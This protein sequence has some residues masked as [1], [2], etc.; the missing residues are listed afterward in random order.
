MS[1]RT[2]FFLLVVG[3]TVIPFLIAS[4]LMIS[5]TSGGDE[6][7]LFYEYYIT[8]RWVRKNLSGAEQG[9]NLKKLIAEKPKSVEF[10]V[11]NGK[12]HILYSTV[13][14]PARDSN[15]DSSR[16]LK[17]VHDNSKSYDFQILSSSLDKKNTVFF[18][19]QKPGLEK[20]LLKQRHLLSLGLPLF[21]LLFSAGMSI[22]IV[23]SIRGSIRTLES[24]TRKIADGDLD[25]SLEVHGNDE[26][27]SLKRS[28]ETMRLKVKEELAKRARFIMGV[29]HD[30]K[31]PLALIEGYVDA[32]QDGYADRPEKMEK[33]LSIIKDK[34]KI[35]EQRIARLIDFV[36]LETGDWKLT[37]KTVRMVSFLRSLCGRYSEDAEILGYV[38][39]SY[40]DIPGTVMV[41][42][43]Q[44]LAMRA[45]EN[46]I[47]NAI[48]YS[49]KGSAIG[50]EAR[51]LSGRPGTAGMAEKKEKTDR[52][53]IS[54]SNYGGK[55]TEEEIRFIFEPFYRGS[56]SRREDGLG[57][58]LATVKTIIRSHGWSI[59]VLSEEKKDGTM[60]VFTVCI[61]ITS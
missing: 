48:R 19:I 37:N 45:F 34:S 42:M 8:R 2:K 53:E 22:Y 54:I 4:I 7:S 43:D 23:R 24:A 28:F 35:L 16:V 26:I 49:A 55:I 30:L 51:V 39:N 14:L 15:S 52:V 3:I 61:P 5:V 11:I 12:Y 46:I 13:K 44:E 29:S 6:H 36:K 40:I 9:I 41:K 59:D 32:I 33:Y 50:L 18:I 25:F 38:F 58:G 27:A 57:L 20:V 17:Y 60:T 10:I 21:L 31:T 1:L 56:N 47:N